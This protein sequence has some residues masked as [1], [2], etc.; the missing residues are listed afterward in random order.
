MD[1]VMYKSWHSLVFISI[2]QIPKFW[3]DGFKNI[4][5][6]NINESWQIIIQKRQCQIL[7][8]PQIFESAYFTI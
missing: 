1:T 2:G 3:I 7:W 4:R 6:L 5:I 8:P